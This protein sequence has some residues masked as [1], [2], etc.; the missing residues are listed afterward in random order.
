MGHG[1]GVLGIVELSLFFDNILEVKISTLFGSYENSLPLVALLSL[2]GQF[3]LLVSLFNSKIQ[4]TVKIVGNLLLLLS[5]CLL[6][7]DF[8]SDDRSQISFMTGLAFLGT[9]IGL[10]LMIAKYK[11][12]IS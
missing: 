12:L 1:Y 4:L 3:V 5:F 7:K 8:V 10:F 2:I 9:S 6:S 11:K